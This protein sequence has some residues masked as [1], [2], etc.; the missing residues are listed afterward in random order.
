MEHLTDSDLDS[1]LQ[2]L[3]LVTKRYLII[4]VPKERGLAFLLKHG[5][6]RLLRYPDYSISGPEFFFSTIGRLDK[7]DRLEHKGFDYAAL[8]NRIREFFP[9]LIIEGVGGL[10]LGCAF[11]VGMVARPMRS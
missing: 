8:A 4:T 1:Y 5:L 2:A 11:T 3:A 10:P 6:K 7:V 9:R